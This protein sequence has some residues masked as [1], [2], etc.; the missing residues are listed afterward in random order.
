M[1]LVVV[2]AD[3]GFVFTAYRILEVDRKQFSS[4]ASQPGSP[5]LGRADLRP[6]GAAE[7]SP[8]VS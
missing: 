8:L 4:Q 1:K 3:V 7:K 5:V 6:S 2:E